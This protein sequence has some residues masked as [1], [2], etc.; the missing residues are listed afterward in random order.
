MK[1][2]QEEIEEYQELTKKAGHIEEKILT[3]IGD[4]Y[5]NLLG[6]NFYT[7]YFPD[8]QEGEFGSKN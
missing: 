4:F 8:A 6:K 7:W 5:Q 3:H 1:L 2:T